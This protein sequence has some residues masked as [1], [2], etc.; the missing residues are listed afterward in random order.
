MNDIALEQLCRVNRIRLM[1]A[2]EL[3]DEAVRVWGQRKKWKADVDVV[4]LS[5]YPQLQAVIDYNPN[6]ESPML[7]RIAFDTSGWQ[8]H[9][10]SNEW[11]VW[12]KAGDILSAAVIP[13]A[14]HT[15]KRMEREYWL[16]Y[17]R[18]MAKPGGSPQP[19]R[20]LLVTVRLSRSSTGV[21]KVRAIAI[22]EYLL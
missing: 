2:Q 11:F 4:V 17:A 1:Q 5:R 20:A 10:R 19:V 9:E 18:N 8:L 3:C 15:F 16:H 13:P 14:W 21:Q 22:A 12:G 6:N 7:K